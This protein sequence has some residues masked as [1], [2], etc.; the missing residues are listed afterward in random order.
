MAGK[1][2][3]LEFL[4]KE[5]QEVFNRLREKLGGKTVYIP[6][7][8][9]DPYRQYLEKRNKKIRRMFERYKKL[10]LLEEV[11]FA[12]ISNRLSCVN[13]L[14]MSRI[15]AIVKRYGRKKL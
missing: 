2:K 14:S 13:K 10:G 1:F 15:R 8:K 7:P 4:S 9:R 6:Y 12:E 3:F 11:I 5:E